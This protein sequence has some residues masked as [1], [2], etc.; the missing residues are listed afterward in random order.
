MFMT[1]MVRRGIAF[2]AISLCFSDN[3][4]ERSTAFPQNRCGFGDSWATEAEMDE[5]LRKNGREWQLITSAAP[6]TVAL[7]QQAD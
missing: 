1:F 5:F 2:A 6:K 7:T 3:Y 4:V